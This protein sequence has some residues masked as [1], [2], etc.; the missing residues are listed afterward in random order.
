VGLYFHSTI[1]RLARGQTNMA[2]GRDNSKHWIPQGLA[3]NL[4]VDLLRSSLLWDFMPRKLV[5]SCRN[6]EKTFLFP[7]SRFRSVK[8]NPPKLLPIG[9]PETSTTTNLLCVS[10]VGWLLSKFRDDQSVT[11]LGVKLDASEPWRWEEKC[12]LEISTTNY[13][14]TWHKI[15]QKRRSQQN[16]V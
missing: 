1:R 2:E 13:Q 6:F 11:F 15:P 12:F 10:R 8:L 3:I 4:H 7:S 9:R 5:V 14:F 16:Y